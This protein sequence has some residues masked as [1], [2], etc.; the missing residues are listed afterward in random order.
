MKANC[1]FHFRKGWAPAFWWFCCQRGLWQGSHFK[2]RRQLQ[3]YGNKLLICK[4]FNKFKTKLTQTDKA[5][6][7][8]EKL[9]K[10]SQVVNKK[11]INLPLERVPNLRPLRKLGLSCWLIAMRNCEYLVQESLKGISK[12]GCTRIPSAAIWKYKNIQM[13]FWK[14]TGFTQHL[15]R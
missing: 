14:S 7:I 12:F 10:C 3:K 13:R 5:T 15:L 11:K 1:I 2:Q 6:D 8:R 4:R 9:S